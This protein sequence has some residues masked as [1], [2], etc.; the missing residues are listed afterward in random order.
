MANMAL[1]MVSALHTNCCHSQ[2]AL[3]TC[4]TIIKQHWP[5]SRHT[6]GYIQII[7]DRA[8]VG[9]YTSR[10]YSSLHMHGAQLS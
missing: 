2:N 9:T 3:P 10:N 1:S 8:H 5:L 7:D 4:S 6:E